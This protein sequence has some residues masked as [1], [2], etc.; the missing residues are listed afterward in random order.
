MTLKLK[1]LRIMWF[2]QEVLKL[3]HYITIQ[4]LYCSFDYKYLYIMSWIKDKNIRQ[5]ARVADPK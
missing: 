1:L 3:L 4:T 2:N 5:R